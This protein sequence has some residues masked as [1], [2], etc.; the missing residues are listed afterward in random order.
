MLYNTVYVVIYHMICICYITHD[1]LFYITDNML[2]YVTHVM[3]YYIT[4]DYVR[5]YNT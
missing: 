5:L 2:C 1:M 4:H 3:L